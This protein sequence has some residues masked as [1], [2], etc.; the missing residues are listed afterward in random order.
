MLIKKPL[1][2]YEPITNSLFKLINYLSSLNHSYLKWKIEIAG[3]KYI[4][5]SPQNT[6]S[7]NF[8]AV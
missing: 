6:N 4:F 1:R 2:G 8:V 5:I 3:N 7:Y